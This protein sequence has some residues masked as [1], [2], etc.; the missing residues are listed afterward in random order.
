MNTK[1]EESMALGAI[2]RQQPVKTEDLVHAAVQQ[3]VNQAN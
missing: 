1:A 2:T 3:I